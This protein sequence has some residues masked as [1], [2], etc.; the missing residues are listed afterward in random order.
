MIV[1]SCDS[2][3]KSFGPEPVLANV[4]F[5]IRQGEQV[6]LVGP[7][8]TGKTTLLNILTGLLEPDGGR[9]FRPPSVR[10]GYLKQQA[11]FPD[12]A[13]VS[14]AARDA[15]AHLADLNE[16]SERLAEQISQAADDD[17]RSVLAARFDVIQEQLKHQDAY[18]LDH[19]IE[20]VLHG[21]GFDD[22]T[23]KQPVQQL[24]GG[25]QNRLMLARL[26]LA[27]PEVMILD[28]PSN[29]L[30]I[31]ATA[32]LEDFL[33]SSKQTLIVVSHDRYFLDKVT[34]RTLELFRGTIVSYRGNF[35]GYWKQK[36]ERVEFEKRTYENQQAE[37]AKLEDFIR[38]NHHGQKHAQAEDR[39]RKLERIVPVDLPREII[40]PRMRF[41]E[42]DRTGDIVLRAESIS[43]AFNQTLFRDLSVDVLRGERWGIMGSNGSGKTT[44][45]KCLL[46]EAQVDDGSI[47]HG[48]GVK[49]GY[50]DQL[51]D[52]LGRDQPAVEAVRPPKK[53]FN[54]QQRRDLLAA[55]GIIGD[56]AF[57]PIHQLSG[58]EKN[59]VALA[60]LAAREA[61][62]LVLD[63]PTNHLDLWARDA[64]EDAIRH[65][66][67]TVLFVSHDR[68]FLN[69]V[70]DHLIV[71]DQ[72]SFRVVHGNYDLYQR[73]AQSEK[74]AVGSSSGKT[75]DSHSKSADARKSKPRRKRQFPY[76][77]VEDIESDIQNVESTV[78]RLHSQLLD[79]EVL[80][81]GRRVKEVQE[82]IE[83]T[84]TQLE[85]LYAHW[86]EASELN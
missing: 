67:G 83:A 2:I 82:Q 23:F 71:L 24:S 76:R 63:E 16:E 47:T 1:L 15:L 18:H 70:A 28:E 25:Q 32:W 35:S 84:K 6:G 60:R 65:F 52:K 22:A 4:S 34:D 50:F 13:T 51:L 9:V 59:R 29:H 46:N 30:D 38:R 37:I 75:D 58:G 74:E 72:G 8:G 73:I 39:R 36:E 79:P 7:N 10:L 17:E 27:A 26:L 42:V 81:D 45:L 86:E 20:R 41:P 14:D 33:V 21:V 40:A 54:E 77:K 55:F 78:D 12:G 49:I 19:R 5:D 85:D 11:D 68:F 56:M 57:Q 69:R 3:S 62:L 64:L 43:K 66:Q 61:N 48:T 44:L 80:K 31:E 53:E